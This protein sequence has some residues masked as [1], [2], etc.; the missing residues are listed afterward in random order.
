MSRRFFVDSPVTGQRAQL[1]GAECRHLSQVLR[2][3]AG[4]T[5]T[6]FDGSGMEYCARVIT[7]GRSCVD[8]E[9]LAGQKVSR[10][11]DT[12]IT[13]AVA[14]PK[15]ERQR[16]L[17]EKAVE[18]GVGCVVPLITDR[19]VAR[20]DQ[21]VLSRLERYVLE[22][23]KQCGRNRLMEIAAA[24]R[25]AD[26]FAAAP[27]DSLRILAHVTDSAPG[28]VQ[29]ASRSVAETVLLAVGPEGGFSDQEL[30]A[31]GQWQM[32]SLGPRTLR[33]ETAALALVAYFSL[34]SAPAA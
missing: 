11:L 3:R 2:A 15:G 19:A 8:L 29:L 5:V 23:S 12:H 24:E 20:P 6:L 33:T 32:V 7:V 31:A 4:D 17:T 16:W 28:I 34:H 13:L 25:A 1:T 30:A 21:R 18:L 26:F 14:L 27:T 10:E 9:V 22:A